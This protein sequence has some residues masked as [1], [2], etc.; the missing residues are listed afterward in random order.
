M[1]YRL[2]CEAWGDQKL[3]AVFLKNH[4]PTVR[5]EF[6]EHQ[7]VL[8]ATIS[9]LESTHLGQVC[10]HFAKETLSVLLN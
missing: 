3:R 4:F 1:F 6:L 9:L 5:N 10:D 2:L 8:Y 7:N